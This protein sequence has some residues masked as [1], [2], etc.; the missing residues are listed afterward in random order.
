MHFNHPSRRVGICFPSES[1]SYST[2]VPLAGNVLNDLIYRDLKKIGLKFKR[3]GNN[4]I[5]WKNLAIKSFMMQTSASSPL[6]YS[7][8]NLSI[9][10]CVPCKSWRTSTRSSYS[11]FV[12]PGSGTSSLS[13]PISWPLRIYKIYYNAFL[14]EL[15][16]RYTCVMPLETH[17]W[18]YKVVGPVYFGKAVTLSLAFVATKVSKTT[19]CKFQKIESQ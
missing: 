15:T 16:G 4:T 13:D 1:S 6:S 12:A 19:Y 7:C 2:F 18:S 3:K 9:P 11:Y 14:G 5:F 10:G 17:S 8:I